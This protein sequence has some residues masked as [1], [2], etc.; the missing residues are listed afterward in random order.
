MSSGRGPPR[1]GGHSRGRGANFGAGRGTTPASSGSTPGSRG[2]SSTQN[3]QPGAQ[4]VRNTPLIENRPR[5]ARGTPASNPN[6]TSLN[7]AAAAFTPNMPTPGD[8]GARQPAQQNLGASG[9]SGGN[10]A[11]RQRVQPAGQLNFA[12]VAAQG[13][14]RPTNAT[15]PALPGPQV[16][17]PPNQAGQVVNAPTAPRTRLP[18]QQAP[19]TTSQNTDSVSLGA[20]RLAG[21]TLTNHYEVIFPRTGVSNTATN[22]TQPSTASQATAASSVKKTTSTPTT[23]RKSGSSI[24]S[25]KR[26]SPNSAPVRSPK[27]STTSSPQGSS[28]ARQPSDAVTPAR[29][30]VL[31][32][33]GFVIDR[34]RTDAERKRDQEKAEEEAKKNQAKS[35]DKGK[36]KVDPNRQPPGGSNPA[37][38]PSPRTPSNQTLRRIIF[39]LIKSLQVHPEMANTAIASNYHDFLVTCRPL[40]ATVTTTH[41]VILYGDHE[42]TPGQYPLYTVTIDVKPL[43]LPIDSLRNFLIGQDGMSI[44]EKDHTIRALN[45][46]F[47]KAANMRTFADLHPIAGNAHSQT[48]ARSGSKKFFELMPTWTDESG[49]KQLTG[50]NWHLLGRLGFYLSTRAFL[51]ADRVFV[52]I[53][54]TRSAFYHEGSLDA[55]INFLLTRVATNHQT[56]GDT[57]YNPRPPPPKPNSPPPPPLQDLWWPGWDDAM[58]A[59]DGLKVVTTYHHDARNPDRCN[60]MLYTICPPREQ[61][62]LNDA[63]AGSQKTSDALSNIAQY[64]QRAYSWTNV[65]R[66][67][68][69]V[70][71]RRAPDSQI[72]YIPTKLLTLI[73][74][75]RLAEKIEMINFAVKGNAFNC[76]RIQDQGRQLF[77]LEAVSPTTSPVSPLFLC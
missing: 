2:I 32:R 20:V 42:H 52:N 30:F 31:Y 47:T 72:D 26:A 22:P 24:A 39:L 36:R 67:D 44:D 71:V 23:P 48:V 56:Q 68:R 18:P 58:Y 29:G 75:Q 60:E 70:A 59:I 54:T 27:T 4:Q 6:A 28:S 63:T 62:S 3:V 76:T 49:P 51:G 74:G 9:G 34:L 10:L 8:S 73:P 43:E 17:R 13:Q 55:Y 65:S 7:P 40:P 1:G 25:P 57:L 66:P 11:N 37:T 61:P 5:T 14:G 69:V 33:Y 64:F 41:Q 45:A 15:Q 19:P 77:E 50:D 12:Q 16:Q 53:N 35:K 38:T 46:I 21:R